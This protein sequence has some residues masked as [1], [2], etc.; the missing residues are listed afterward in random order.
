MA[1]KRIKGATITFE[2]TDDGTLRA[3]GQKAK[4][5]KKGLDGVSKS[6]RDVNR[7]MQAMSGRVESGTKG[8]ARMQQGTGGLVQTYAILASTLFAVGAAFRALENAAN[9]QNQ[10]KG[11]KELAAITG[12]SMLT[13][14]AAVRQATGGLLEFQAAAQQTAIATA[15][16]F[17]RDQIVGLAEGAKLAS[18]AL[19]RDMTDSFNRLIRGVTKAEPELLDELG[20]ILRLDIATR[21]FAATQ[22]LVAE[23]LT[24]AQRRMAVYNEVQQQLDENFGA[25]GKDADQYLNAFTRFA[26]TISDVA[27][28]VGGFVTRVLEPVV[29]FLDRSS[30]VLG[31]VL[32]VIAFNMLKQVVPAANDMSGALTRFSQRAKDKL[33]EYD[34][35][36]EKTSAK[37]KKAG[38][39]TIT[40][41]GSVSAAF[42]KDLKKRG[43]A[44]KFFNMR[45]FQDQKAHITK[46][47][48]QLPRKTKAEKATAKKIET[49][50]RAAYKKI[51]MAQKQNLTKAGLSLKKVGLQIEKF[52]SI[53][54]QKAAH[55]VSK[56]GQAALAAAPAV[57]VLG[58]AASTLMGF[59]MAFMTID[60]VMELF[61]KG[62]RD[63]K[64]AI[65]ELKDQHKK[66]ND[67]TDE[68]MNVLTGVYK[69][70]QRALEDSKIEAFEAAA[71][72]RFMGNALAG[73]GDEKAI[74]KT[75]ED[76]N[77]QIQKARGGLFNFG[78]AEGQGRENAGRFL[79]NQVLQGLTDPNSQK[80]IQEELSKMLTDVEK[81][82]GSGGNHFT[83]G[84]VVTI[85]GDRTRFN[86]AFEESLELMK[87]SETRME[88]QAALVSVLEDFNEQLFTHSGL[89]N[90]TSG[91]T[92]MLSTEGKE[93][94]QTL[95]DATAATKAAGEGIIGLDEAGKNL[96]QTLDQM[97]PKPSMFSNFV[98]GFAQIKTEI[99]KS[100]LEEFLL[101]IDGKEYKGLE[102]MKNVLMEQIGISEEAAQL[103]V[104]QKD[105]LTDIFEKTD[106]LIR[107]EKTY[108]SLLDTQKKRLM[109]FDTSINRRRAAML[110]IEKVEAQRVRAQAELA[111]KQE[112]YNKLNTDMKK[113]MQDALDA[114]MAQVEALEAQKA[115]LEGNLNIAKAFAAEILKAADAAGTQ[116]LKDALIGD[117]SSN[118]IRE[119]LAKDLQ[120]AGAGFIAGK[121]MELIGAGF[122]KIMP[123]SVKDL[124]GVGKMS[125][126]AQEFQT[127]HTAHVTGMAS[128]LTQHVSGVAQVMGTKAPGP[129]TDKSGGGDGTGTGGTGTSAGDDA[130]EKTDEKTGQTIASKIEEVVTKGKGTGET[131]FSAMFGDLGSIFDVFLGDLKGLFKGENGLFGEGGLFANLKAGLFGGDGAGK[132][133]FG[134]FMQNLTGEGGGFMKAITGAIGGGG[135]GGLL[136]GLMG[137]GGGGLL[138][139][140]LGGGK[141]GIMGLLKPLLGM[142]PG[143]GPLLSILPFAKGGIIGNKMHALEKGGVMPRYAKGGIATQPTYLV[144]EG[145]KNEAVVPLPDNKSIPVDL[146]RGAGNENN[147]SISVNMADGS[148]STKSDAESGKQLGAAINAAVL[149]ELE[150]QQ[151]PGG[152]LQ[153]QG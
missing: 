58:V 114:S 38:K 143:I 50:Y 118:E 32:S 153:A 103:L 106:Q 61:S 55:F 135:S 19:G 151:R 81:K 68:T 41:E 101:N 15:A 140:L 33:T 152:M 12:T 80:K 73:I 11:F 14:T 111:S 105:T 24:I 104:D 67:V 9:I 17:S 72:I 56:I 150:R 109:F 115:V 4:G 102:G 74:I 116:A 79:M 64:E 3:V 49:M 110:D 52:V 141:S 46:Y 18:V 77:K 122:D 99:E 132:G 100:G 13:T 40:V 43:V 147:V 22:G 37:I 119:K 90:E 44:D 54:A 70:H 71:A 113:E 31:V 123:Q 125:K 98:S 30:G 8:F 137:G 76:I 23:K 92:L 139:G 20:I 94:I 133:I 82:I 36:I 138:G 1:G 145:K 34:A 16:G 62:Y 128:V 66:L 60:F 127:V 63:V 96:R 112:I 144:G 146:G 149:Q 126:E 117:K 28:D 95:V 108:L 10:I 6:T 142:I 53:P 35:Q 57:R 7:N 130:K 124:F 39:K 148:T 136:G 120:S 26:T 83:Q 134:N 91:G 21:K 131:G 47:L 121:G 69:N 86:K 93:F 48:K 87:D 78:R 65:A 5:A 51:E 84:S 2:V 88:G 42:K 25:F 129:I 27:K 85:A 29:A 97:L 59:L 89:L 107:S 45:R 75:F